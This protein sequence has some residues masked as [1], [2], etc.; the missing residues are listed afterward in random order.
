VTV[1]V[2]VP[3]GAEAL[4]QRPFELA[5]AEGRPLAL[6]DVSLVFEAAGGVTGARAPVGERLRML[7][8]FSVPTDVS[9]LALRRERY[10]LSRLVHEIAVREGRALELRVRAGRSRA[11][12]ILPRPTPDKA[13]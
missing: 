7:A 5:H 3:A 11:A 12:D 6:Q 13:L 9:A 8:V 1:R 2:R 4:L 10:R